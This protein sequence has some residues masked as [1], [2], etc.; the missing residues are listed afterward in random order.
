MNS[1]A[2]NTNIFKYLIL[3]LI[4]WH[5]PGFSLVYI[6]GT[7]SSLLSYASYGLILLYVF[8]N[9]KTG[10]SYEMLVLGTLYYG[11]SILVTQSYVADAYTF[12]VALIKYYI[13]I[14]GGYEVV[15]NT[16]Q[17]ELWFFLFIGALSILGNVFLFQNPI[18]DYGRYSGF[19]LDAN[20]GGLICL[21]GFALSFTITKSLRL[22]SKL[23]YTMLGLITFSRTFMVTWLL[24]NLMSIRLSI[25]NSKMLLIGFGVLILLVTYNEFLPVRNERLDQLSALISGSQSSKISGLNK[26]SREDTWAR[27][28][29][30]LNDRPIFGNGYYSFYGNG[31]APT[32]WGVHNTYLLIWGEAGIFPLLVF[33]FFLGKLFYKS[34]KQFFIKSYALLMITGLSLFFMTNHNFMTNEYAIFIL[35]WIDVQLKKSLQTEHHKGVNFES[36]DTLISDSKNL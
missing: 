19:Y 8:L 13:V 21:M 32:K 12:I 7:L 28:Y 36:S 14:W 2:L 9:K 5:I 25:K 23:S 24:L 4:L 3:A 22:F 17:K 10:N 15:K 33:L 6:N 11:I 20:N 27:Y 18:A 31:A 16:S 1:K 34:I 26:D 35:M 30:A 29:D